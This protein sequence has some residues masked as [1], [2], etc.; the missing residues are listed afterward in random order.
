MISLQH[1]QSILAK[2]APAAQ[3]LETIPLLDAL[4]RVASSDVLSTLAIPPADNSAM[5][6]F[7]ARA[8][9][10]HDNALLA[11]SQRLPAGAKP[12]ALQA[13]TVAR[14]FTGANMPAG[15]DTVVIQ[16][17]CEFE[18]SNVG[19]RVR[20][21]KP[22]AK[23]ANIRPRGQDIQ[24][25]ATVVRRGQRLNAVDLSLLA[26]I[27]VAEIQVFERLKVAIFS[28]GDELVEPG[29]PLQE[30]QIYN[31]NRPLL[32][33]LCA[34]LGYQALDCG[35][36]AD[37][38]DDTK[39]ALQEAAQHAHLILSS[40]G[41]SVGEED[42]IKPAIE[43]LGSLDMWKVQIK[44]GKPV[45]YGKV[46]NAAFLGLPGNPVS[47]FVVFQLLGL[48]LM[49]AL[50]GDQSEP[51]KVFKVT[52]G[53]DKALTTREEYVRVKLVQNEH[54]DWVADRF[55]NLSSGVLSSLSW[56]DG[57]VKHNIDTAI[58]RGQMVEFLPLRRAML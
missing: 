4:G 30:G 18:S 20:I 11:V 13:G 53:F 15:A 6:G 21:V 55:P 22:P 58:E 2:A 33:A 8:E 12:Q 51:P 50:Q 45:A 5:D 36:V 41:V 35:I 54:G 27:G 9:D 23:G 25:G 14:I 16:E 43:S 57:L 31:S 10:L 56:A 49:R 39:A 34:Q 37:T 1:A 48:P 7:A 44:P 40:G 47:S 29:Q 42:H 46:G 19:E 28:T 17:H 52:A 32:F 38:L 24:L 26:S 3:T